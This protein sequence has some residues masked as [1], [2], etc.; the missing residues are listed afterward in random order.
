MSEVYSLLMM[1]WLKNDFCKVLHK[2]HSDVEIMC[3]GGS[4]AL[5]P[6]SPSPF[7]ICQLFYSCSKFEYSL[8]GV[9]VI[10]EGETFILYSCIYCLGV[11][12]KSSC[13]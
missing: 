8:G 7:S 13:H 10:I 4:C 3:G 11:D 2:L 9:T 5:Y 1:S 12:N 6:S